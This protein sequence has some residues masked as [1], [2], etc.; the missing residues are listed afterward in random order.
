MLYYPIVAKA[1]NCANII[2]ITAGGDDLINAAK[3]FI[4]NKNEETISHAIK[5]SGNNYLKNIRKNSPSRQTR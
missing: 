2:T 1:V 3:G 5:Q 4:R